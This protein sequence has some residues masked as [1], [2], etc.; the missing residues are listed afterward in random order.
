MSLVNMETDSGVQSSTPSHYKDDFI[1]PLT[2]VATVPLNTRAEESNTKFGK[3]PYPVLF[4][5]IIWFLIGFTYVFCRWRQKA[6]AV[7]IIPRVFVLCSPRTVQFHYE[8]ILRVGLPSGEFNP[9]K[10]DI[11]ITVQGQHRNEIVPMTRLNTRTLVDE[12]LITSLSMIV[13]RLVEMPTLGSLIL[14]HSGPFKASLYVYDFTVIDLSTNKEQYYTINRYL[15]SLNRE[16]ALEENHDITNVHYPIDDVPMPQWSIED[17]FLIIGTVSNWIMLSISLLPV[18]CEADFKND[19]ASIGMASLNGGAIVF[20]LDWLLYYHGRWNQD[21]REYFNLNE[22]TCCSL[23]N[24]IRIIVAAT[25]MAAGLVAVFI[26]S[27]V[28]DWRDSVVWLLATTNTCILV[29]GL[30]NIARQAELGETFVELGL[31]CRGIETVGVG[32]SLSDIVSDMQTKSVSTSDDGARST[33]SSAASKFSQS[34]GPRSS[35]KTF[36]FDSNMFQASRPGA[37]SKVANLRHS[38]TGATPD[39]KYIPHSAH[40]IRPH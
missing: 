5:V 30:W 21:R 32:M 8:L 20:F 37:S 25:G 15:G 10:H 17:M 39:L 33:M 27:S 35:V 18:N 3:F 12:P 36:G 19:I 29:I 2:S 4:I 31:K 23:D 34:I 38:S 13:Y 1:T 9:D 26:C 11:D 16:Y 6:K 22:P 24:W 7:Y 28:N 40:K 14:R